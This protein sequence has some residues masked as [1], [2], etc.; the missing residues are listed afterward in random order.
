MRHDNKGTI[1]L[2]GSKEKPTPLNYN[3]HYFIIVSGKVQGI[4]GKYEGICKKS[5][6]TDGKCR[7]V[8]IDVTII[9]LNGHKMVFLICFLDI[10]VI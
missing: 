5:L 3:P 9:L 4:I 2:A 1:L 6:F 8:G 10:N 7:T